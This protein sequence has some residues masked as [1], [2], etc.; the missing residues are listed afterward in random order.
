MPDLVLTLIGPDR[1]GIVEAIAEPVARHGGNWLESRMAH[2]AGKFAGILRLEV[3]ADQVQPLTQALHGLE[4]RGLRINVEASPAAA[5]EAGGRLMLLDLMGL[6]RPGIVREISHAL[7]ERG[8]NIEE[9]TTDRTSAAMSGELL[10]RSRAR[11][12]VPPRTDPAQLRETL[13]KLAGD[14][15]V[16]VTLAEPEPGRS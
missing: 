11:V 13:E 7:A 9:L 14:L 10:F 15:M 1:P 4:S 3:P 5:Q 16:Q 2:L 8:V 12:V 6:D